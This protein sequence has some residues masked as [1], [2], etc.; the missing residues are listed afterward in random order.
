MQNDLKW[1]SQVDYMCTKANRKMFIIRKLKEAGF[2][3][4][5]LICIYKGYIRPVLEYAAPLWHAALTQAQVNQVERIQKRIC[6]IILGFDYN[7]YAVSLANLD[8]QPLHTRRLN[9]CKEFASKT[10]VSGRFSNWFPAPEVRT[11]MT[12]R[13]QRLI[14]HYKCNTKRFQNSPIPFMTDLINKLK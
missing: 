1:Q 11:S 10:H 13:N 6:K 12:L 7:T 3:Q 4:N 2:T 9:I 14:K 5:E 8:L